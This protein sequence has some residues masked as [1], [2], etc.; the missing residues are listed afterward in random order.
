MHVPD[1]PTQQ[2]DL[3]VQPELFCAARA[4]FES[5]LTLL[6]LLLLLLLLFWCAGTAEGHGC[7][8]GQ[9][10]QRLQV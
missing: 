8:A 1:H 9:L 10:H 6:L 7:C 5:K 4:A 3:H 2:N